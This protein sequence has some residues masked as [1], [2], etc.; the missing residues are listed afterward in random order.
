MDGSISSSGWFCC[1]PVTEICHFFLRPNSVVHGDVLGQAAPKMMSWCLASHAMLSEN[2]T[3]SNADRASVAGL[4]FV[5]AAGACRA[6]KCSSAETD[7][8]GPHL[9]FRPACRISGTPK[10]NQKKKTG[11]MLKGPIH[12]LNKLLQKKNVCGS[13]LQS[14]PLVMLSHGLCN[15]VNFR[16]VDW[17]FDQQSQTATNNPRRWTSSQ[18]NSRWDC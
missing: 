12:V 4:L 2:T 8:F 6:A 5:S 9:D 3:S 11:L 10:R 13:D 7:R 17:C 18:A 16:G 14:W 1:S 15:R